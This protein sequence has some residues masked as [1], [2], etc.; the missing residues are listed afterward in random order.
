MEPTEDPGETSEGAPLSA[1][2][3]DGLLRAFSAEHRRMVVT[4][5]AQHDSASVEELTDVV[6]GWSQT[7]DGS[8]DA[9]ESW[10]QTYSDLYH[11]HLPALADAGLVE[12]DPDTETATLESL[13]D[14]ASDLH[15]T[16]TELARVG[17]SEDE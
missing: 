14:P 9:D 13:S 12:Y 7:S 15:S 10:L 4:Y 5:L 11:H 2:R 8:A 3:L 1:D 16:I 17:R 6:V